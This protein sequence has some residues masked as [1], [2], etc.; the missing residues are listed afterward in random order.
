MARNYGIESGVETARHRVLLTA[1]AA[2]SESLRSTILSREDMEL[3]R[4]ESVGGSI[5]ELFIRPCQLW[6]VFDDRDGTLP[7]LL[8]EL[9]RQ[10]PASN[11]SVIVLTPDAPR[12]PKKGYIKF[13]SPL[14]FDLDALNEA[15]AAALNLPRRRGVRLPIRLDLH[16]GPDQSASL[17]TTLTV[18]PVGMLVET[19]N[20][21]TVGREYE[22]RFAGVKGAEA[23][24]AISARV[25]RQEQGTEIASRLRFYS[26]EFVGVSKERMEEILKAI[27]AA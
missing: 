8:D 11:L 9:Y 25:I 27:V 24:P 12:F 20:E 6:V 23:L 15:I 5:Q 16:L 14:P 2:Q 3:A 13:V 4:L 26:M 7:G 17:A 1:T 18:S 19:L 21:L 10:F 22:F